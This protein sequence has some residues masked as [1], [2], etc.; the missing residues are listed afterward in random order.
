LIKVAAP[1]RDQVKLGKAFNAF[2]DDLE[3]EF[4]RHRDHRLDDNAVAFLTDEVG[5]HRTVDLYRIEW[6]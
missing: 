5:D 2:D 4:A 1:G 3:P 6:E